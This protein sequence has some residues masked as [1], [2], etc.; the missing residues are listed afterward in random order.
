MRYDREGP[1]RGN[2]ATSGSE[3][4]GG[5]SVGGVPGQ[6][7]SGRNSLAV[8]SPPVAYSS[9]IARSADICRWP[10]FAATQV[11]Q[12]G[13]GLLGDIRDVRGGVLALK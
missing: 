5:G 1:P 4:A 9:Q 3:V 11:A 12:A 2:Q 6:G 7:K 10:Y 13:S 8:S